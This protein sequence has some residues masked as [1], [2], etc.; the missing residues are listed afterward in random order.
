MSYHVTP[1]R[2]AKIS[3]T[4]NKCWWSYEERGTLLYCWWEYKQMQP[5]WKTLWRFLKKLKI[6]LPYNPAIALL[7]IYPKNTKIL[8]QRDTWTPMFISAMSPIGRLWE[9]LRRPSTD[10]WIKKTLCV[11][12]YI[13]AY[14]HTHIHTHTHTHTHTEEYYSA[15]RKDEYLQFTST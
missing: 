9:E 12:I 10:E 6:E 4:R 14:T 11:C 8:I 5:F 1:V 3:N 7:G 13:Y 2:M 15:I